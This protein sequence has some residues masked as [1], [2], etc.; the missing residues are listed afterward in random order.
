MESSLGADLAFL[1]GR[2]LDALAAQIGRYP[3][4]ASL[5][6]IEGEVTNAAGTLALHV[7]GNLR[8][9]VG[10]VLGGSG[11]VRDR[12][13]EFTRREPG[14]EDLQAMVRACRAEVVPVLEGLDDRVLAGPYPGDLPA[15][16]RGATTR[17][18][19]LHLSGHLMWHLGQMDY[20]RR[21]LGGPGPG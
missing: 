3:D 14:R 18:F 20:H 4:D 15:S 5:W 9:Y 2:D 21:L 11:Y 1:L 8:H 16:L 17:R 7:V 6:R 10:G 12:E 13:A 19:L